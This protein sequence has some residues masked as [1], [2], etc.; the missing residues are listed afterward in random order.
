MLVTGLGFHADNEACDSKELSGL[1]KSGK[2]K[3]D[4]SETCNPFCHCACC[5]FSILLPEKTAETEIFNFATAK[6][7]YTSDAA[8]VRISSSI[9]QP[10]KYA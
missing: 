6:L 4:K 10:P 9:W 8:P 7:K 2:E 5:P 1:A 3:Q